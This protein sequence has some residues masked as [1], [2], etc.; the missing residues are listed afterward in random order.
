MLPTDKLSAKEKQALAQIVSDPI[1][2]AEAVLRD[3]DTFTHEPL[4]L[5]TVEKQILS[6]KSRKTIIR[7]HR[8]AG[9]SYSMAIR[10][11]WRVFTQESSQVLI[12]CPDQ[13]KVDVLFE[14]INDFIRV[15]PGLSSSIVNNQK[16]P[17]AMRFVN[18]STIKGF[19]TGASSNREATIL[20]GQGADEVIID[21][22]AFL[23]TND[24]PS[25][26]PIMYG[27]ANRL[28]TCWVAGTPTADRGIYYKW[29]TESQEGVAEPWNR[30]FM[31]VIDNPDYPKDK[32]EL[33]KHAETE[34]TWNQEW[35]AEFP[36]IGAGVFKNS[37]IDRA[38]RDY[39][40]YSKEEVDQPG[41]HVPEAI[42]TMGVDW[43][44]FQAGPNIVILELDPTAQHFKVI[45][46]EEIPT[47]DY[48]LNEAVQRV[49][50]LDT[51]FN[52]NHIYVDR[53]YGE[54]QVEALHKHGVDFPHTNLET[55]VE[56]YT[57]GDYVE[58]PD[59]AGGLVKKPLKPVM[60]NI[61]VKWMEDNKFAYSKYHET[62]TTQLEGYKV[63]GISKSTVKY[64][65]KNEH[66]I[67][68][69]VLAAYALH[70]NFTDPFKYVAATESFILPAPKYVTD[71]TDNLPEF[72][73]LIT[74]Q[75]DSPGP[76]KRTFTRG[77]LPPKDTD[78]SF[79]RK[80]F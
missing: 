21:E 77:S 58:V 75:T 57:F 36:D 74:V 52:C 76:V 17:A 31:S 80:G 44:K 47:N 35:L 59:P 14:L 54:M 70:K 45:Y 40:Y 34:A 73:P 1:L 10:A 37:Y 79:Q 6:S 7:V 51:I 69:T 56:G 30:I 22:A 28:V 4:V 66:I 15:S 67:D 29:C 11:L 71:D 38:Q 43:D 18:G 49:I 13:S 19:T 12:I 46:A 20:R 53:G 55:K 63:V 5:N 39:Y 3:P 41:F 24:W 61:L 23:S 16:R 65:D 72:K 64:S 33:I 9:K 27:D 68:A 25:I 50:A 32:V 62:F 48:V 26:T 2:W 78:F 60:I 42:R 8:R